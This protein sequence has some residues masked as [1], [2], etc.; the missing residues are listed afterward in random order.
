MPNPCEQGPLTE[1][2]FNVIAQGGK[3][4]AVAGSDKVEIERVIIGG[5]LCARVTHPG[6]A[7]SA[8]A[9]GVLRAA[10]AGVRVDVAA[11]GIGVLAQAVGA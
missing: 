5:K 8:P 9:V 6:W 11:G 3:E 4:E 7:G 2:D 10:R 1:D